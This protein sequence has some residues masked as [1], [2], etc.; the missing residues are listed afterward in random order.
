MIVNPNAPVPLSFNFTFPPFRATYKRSILC[1]YVRPFG[2]VA[3]QYC[4]IVERRFD[5]NDCCLRIHLSKRDRC[6]ANKSARVNYKASKR[7]VE[8]ELQG[9][10]FR[11]ET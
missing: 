9:T 6:R 7:F 4:K 5:S 10:K 1:V 3:L 2:H 8:S 11:P